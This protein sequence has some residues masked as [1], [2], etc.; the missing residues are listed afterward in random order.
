MENYTEKI[1][2]ANSDQG[3]VEK[4]IKIEIPKEEWQ[5]LEIIAQRVGGDFGMEV[6]LGKVGGGSFFNPEDN[7]ITF[8]PLQIIE[9]LE[10]AKF[11]AGHEGAHRAI[12]PHP[13]ELGLSQEKIRELYS[14]IGFGYL[15]NAIEDPVVNDWMRRRFPGLDENIRKFYNKQ[16]IEEN[17]VLSS[18][19]VQ[20][21]TTLLGYWPRFAQFGSEVI[22]DWHQRRFSQN[23][24]PAVEKALGRTIDHARKSISTIPEQQDKKGII[25]AAQERF[26]INTYYVWPEVKKLVE[27]DLSTEEQRQMIKEFL[28]KQRELKQKREELEQAKAQGDDK[29]QKELQT[30]IES[31]EKELNP[32]NQLPEDI[33]KELQ[34]QIDRMIQETVEQLNK[35]IE[36]KER[37]IQEARQR[38][39]QLEREIKELEERIENASDTEK[40]ELEKQLQEKRAEKLIQEIKQQQ[41]EQ[42]LNDIQDLFKKINSGE[43]IPYPAY[44]ISKETRQELEKLKKKLPLKKQNDLREKAKE[45]LED[46]EDAI[47][48]EMQGK[49]TEQKPESHRERREREKAEKE[50]QKKALEREEQMK[51]VEKELTRRRYEQM[52]PY[53]RA[54][55]EVAGL[56]DHLYLS[57]RRILRPKEYS[58]EESGYISG[59]RLDVNRAMQAEKDILQKQKLWIRETAPERKD[60]RFWLLVDLSGSMAGEKIEETFK[61]MIVV[62]EAIDRIE[63]LNSSFMTIHQGISG[64]HS[65]I[66]PFKDFNQRYTKEIEDSLSTILDRVRDSDANTNT[67][68]ATRQA[69]E[70]LKKDLGKSGNFLLTFSDGVPNRDVQ[71]KLKTL[72]REGKEERDRLGI[73]VG[74]IWLGEIEDERKLRELILEYGYDFGLMMPAIQPQKKGEKDFP[75]RLADLLQDMI[76]QPEKY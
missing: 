42:E 70:E 61:G 5:I 12:T 49:L 35:K 66:F 71:D 21:I 6:R 28:Q 53:E 24:D 46:L 11:V 69:L 31:L 17:A 48:E 74:L 23:L 19:E 75:Q 59:Q 76:E 68:E 54:R 30:E 18:P 43:E 57:L 22:R 73:K 37:E 51:R 4:T 3:E 16:L 13:Q 52:T 25:A 10:I 34:E 32:F 2:S 60:Y 72:L 15:Q 45:Q 26:R 63:N 38:Q 47:N 8:D 55:A 33:K 44:K 9:D 65:R 27:M 67:Y 39:E 1:S 36:E 14:Q 29:R 50:A 20:R 40:E 62:G 7:S 64:F 56:T 41:A 58:G